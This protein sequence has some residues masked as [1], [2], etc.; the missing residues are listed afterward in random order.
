MKCLKCQFDNSEGAKFCNECGNKLE[1]GCPECGK[2]NQ[3]GSRFCNECGHNISFPSDKPPI[4]VSFDDKLAKIQRY[5]PEGLAEK[6]L[7]QKDK[8]EGERKQL[9]VMFCDLVQYTSL[10]EKLDPEETYQLMDAIYELLIHEVHAFQG[11]VNEM[12]GDGILALFGAPIALEDAP[13]RAVQSAI[14]I[15]KELARK[16]V[17]RKMNLKMRIGIHT[18]T[19]V[20]GTLGNDLRVEFKAVGDTV[21]L[22]A[23]IQQLAEP[24]SI[25]ITENTHRLVEGLFRCEAVGKVEVRGKSE[26]VFAFRVLGSGISR[27][28]FEARAEKGLTRFVGRERESEILWDCFERSKEGKGQALSIVAEAGMGKSRL[29]YEFRKSLASE[30]VTFLEGQCVSYGQN[31]PYLP[32]IDILKENFRI[33]IEDGPKE[34]QDKVKRGLEQIEAPPDQTL[35][36]ILEL[37]ALENGF[38][39]LKTIDPESKRRKTFEALRDLTLRGSQVRPLVMA[40]EDLHW[41]DNTSEES[42]IDLVEHIAGAR[43]F[44]IFTFR[45]NYLPPWGGKSYY[46][47]INLNRL[48]NRESLHM[49]TSLLDTDEIEEDVAGLILEKVEGVPFFIEEFTR[50]LLESGSILRADGRCRLKTDLAPVTIPAT[51]HDLLMA[52]VDRL[53]EGAKEILQVGSVIEREFGWTLIKEVTG[54]S[55]MELL[56]RISHLKEAELIFERGIFPQVNYIFQHGITQ[57]L[58]YHSLLTAKQ[59]EYHLAIGKAMEILYSDRLEEHSSILALHFTRGGDPEKGYRYHHLAGDRAAASYANREAT[60]HYREAW[61]LINEEGKAHKVRERRLDTAVKLAIVMEPLGEFEPTLDLLEE[62]LNGSTDME[63]IKGHAKVH[64]WMGNT[65]GNLGRYDD[66]RSHLKRSLELSQKSESKE[67]EGDAHNYLSQLDYFQGYLSSALE[68]ADASV[69][70]LREIGNPTRLAWTL[71][72]T[73]FILCDLQAEGDYQDV[74]EETRSWIER[75]G[76]DRAKCLFYNVNLRNLFKRGQYEES[77]NSALEG[78]KLAEKIGEGIQTVFLLSYAV[79]AALYAGKKDFSLDLLQRGEE[80]GARVKH[81]LGLAHLRVARAETLLRLGRIEESVKPAE[82]AIHFC[83]QLDLGYILQWALEIN[84]EILANLVPPDETRIDKMMKNAATLLERSDSPWYRIRHL[85][86]QARVNLKLTR[87]EVVRESLAAARV[88][89]QDIGI[90]DG[91]AELHSVEKALEELDSKGG[92]YVRGK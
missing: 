66:A 74:I 22:A 78:L 18:G 85:L 50:S 80:A 16:A 52:R 33:E 53:P 68:H 37:F 60:D 25:L 2:L 49:I 48:S 10:S 73:G 27:S 77:L 58:L 15:Q 35:P 47:Q 13:Q 26:P 91:T 44:L 29:L 17:E 89:Y 12:T 9:T 28:R 83:E 92:N 62:V 20:V 87:L 6:I 69:R 76:N 72:F 67:T 57:E 23:R 46:S 3:P 59:R 4:D 64:Y 32:F 45:S 61:R 55:D 65:F 41:I 8:I 19:A 90:D 14:S 81:A 7:S 1:I 63:D 82:A 70:C 31:S 84:A 54:I 51:L 56:S 30:G 24:G 79:L 40:F 11:T 39:A 5:L 86:A 43:V 42:F 75:S 21:N 34:I 38:E 88:F 71:S 36:Y